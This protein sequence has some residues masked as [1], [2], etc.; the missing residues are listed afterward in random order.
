MR[1]ALVNLAHPPGAKTVEDT[2]SA[3]RTLVEWSEALAAAGAEVYAVQGFSRDAEVV[4]GGVH[5]Q[6]LAGPFQPYLHPLR[7]VGRIQARIAALMPEVVHVN[8][9]LYARQGHDL[10]RRL[11]TAGL[12]FQ[13]HAERPHRRGL[14]RWLQRRWLRAADALVW[15]GEAM[16][17]PWRAASLVPSTAAVC[18]IA[19]ASSR[20][21]PAPDRHAARRAAGLEG[22]PL[23]LWLGNLDANKD[24]LTVLAGVEPVL[25]AR[26]R[27][28]LLM[29]FNSAP[30][31]AEVERRIADRPI[32]GR[33]VTLR[34][35]VPYRALE[36]MIQAADL[37]VQGSH[38]EGSGYAVLDA[39]ACGVLPVVTD[40]PS[41]SF[42]TGHGQIGALWPPDAAG[43]LR[44]AL[45]RVLARPLG[46]QQAAARAFFEHQLSYPVLAGQMLAVYRQ[47]RARGRARGLPLGA[48]KR[49]TV[50]SR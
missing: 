26:P 48:G 50:A 5:Y 45:D 19:E 10:G 43:G 34:G 22:D 17:E 44:A 35:S 9:L 38:R 7:L 8:S 12:V 25:A 47:A 37:L 42:L 46:P 1:V 23:L 36:P 49:K 32:L 40:L 24:P 15:T 2:L 14:R 31:R 28:R 33:A 41:L 13:H 4:R 6:L 16:A 18:A 30:L 27:A 21:V 39:L 3:A 11:P 29:C 20:F